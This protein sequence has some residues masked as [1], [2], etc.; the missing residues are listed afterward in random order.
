MHLFP[1][2]NEER[3]HPRPCCKRDD[4]DG[5]LHIIENP[6]CQQEMHGCADCRRTN[7]AQGYDFQCIERI[8]RIDKKVCAENSESDEPVDMFE[9]KRHTLIVA[10]L[11]SGYWSLLGTHCNYS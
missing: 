8:Q 7:R 5:V 1:V 2:N 10:K 9:I 11:E 4:I 3:P 6:K